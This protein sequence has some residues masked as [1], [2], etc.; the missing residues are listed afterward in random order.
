MKDELVVAPSAGCSRVRSNLHSASQLLGQHLSRLT[1][2]H[3]A[4]SRLTVGSRIILKSGTYPEES[5]RREDRKCEGP[6]TE[7]ISQGGRN[8]LYCVVLCC[9]VLYCVA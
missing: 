5:Q 2:Q 4:V 9:A 8:R 7:I 3:D 6:G 1:A